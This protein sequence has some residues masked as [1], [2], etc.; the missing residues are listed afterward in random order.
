MLQGS[1]AQTS[2]LYV[3]GAQTGSVLTDGEVE[4]VHA[5][6]QVSALLGDVTKTGGSVLRTGSLAYVA[7]VRAGAAQLASLPT[8]AV[9]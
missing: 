2:G 6:A 1:A 7:Q 9:L 4:V 8:N 3:Y 5:R